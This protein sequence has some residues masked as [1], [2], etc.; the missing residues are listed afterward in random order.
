[1]NKASGVPEM[2]L[3]GG[4]AENMKAESVTGIQIV[5][6]QKKRTMLVHSAL[7]YCTRKSRC[8]RDA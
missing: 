5:A 7:R 3:C 8:E 4:G 6:G 2:I 1:M